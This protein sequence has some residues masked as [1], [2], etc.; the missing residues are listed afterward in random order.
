MSEKR[1]TEPGNSAKEKNS[2]DRRGASMANLETAT[3]AERLR[4]FRELAGE[5]RISAVNATS[6]EMRAGYERLAKAW[7]HL[8]REI[9]RAQSL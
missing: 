9:E 3:P 8:I 4:Q 6:P 7:D 5:A 2:R 1:L